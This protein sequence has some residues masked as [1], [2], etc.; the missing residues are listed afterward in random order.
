MLYSALCEHRLSIFAF[1]RR[2]KEPN[3]TRKNS[4]H[5]VEF[6]FLLLKESF[7]ASGWKQNFTD[8]WDTKFSQTSDLGVISLLQD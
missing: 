2:Q 3:A 8:P 1:L 6:T 4:R 5:K 7:S